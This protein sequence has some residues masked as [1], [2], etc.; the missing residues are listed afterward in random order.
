MIIFRMVNG[1]EVE[2]D[3]VCVDMET[4]GFYS[5][6]D[7]DDMVIKNLPT[8][9]VVNFYY[10]KEDEGYMNLTTGGVTI[11]AEELLKL[12]KCID[13]STTKY[14]PRD[15]VEDLILKYAKRAVREYK[16]KME[17]DE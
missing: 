4:D 12:Q 1:I 5:V 7:R 11:T 6:I 17:N 13:E 9:G 14:I 10:R 8:E 16:K 2:V 15:L 3:G